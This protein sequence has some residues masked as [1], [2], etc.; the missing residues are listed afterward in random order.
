MSNGD[1]GDGD[2]GRPVLKGTVYAGYQIFKPETPGNGTQSW[3]IQ[4]VEQITKKLMVVWMSLGYPQ[5]AA[6]LTTEI[7]L[8]RGSAPSI[9]SP[10]T[11]TLCP[12][13]NCAEAFAVSLVVNCER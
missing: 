6:R 13:R 4:R 7:R 5:L 9:S 8:I 2:R 10:L 3:P 11:S 1:V 12:S